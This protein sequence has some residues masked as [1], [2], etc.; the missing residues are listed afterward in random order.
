MRVQKNVVENSYFLGNT[1]LEISNSGLSNCIRYVE[2]YVTVKEL[3]LTIFRSL[4]KI[5]FPTSNERY[6]L[7]IRLLF[8]NVTNCLLIL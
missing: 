2:S 8:L 6:D 3:T 1:N 4:Y 5:L 7:S